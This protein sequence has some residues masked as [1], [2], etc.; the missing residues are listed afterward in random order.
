MASIPAED[1]APASKLSR[2]ISGVMACSPVAKA[3]MALR[4]GGAVASCAFAAQGI[5]LLATPDIQDFWEG[6][7]WLGQGLLGIIVGA[8]GTYHEVMGSM[9]SVTR[10]FK[11]FAMNRIGLCVFYL[12]MGCYIMGG[13]GVVHSGEA[14]TTV[15]HTTG[16]LAWAVAIGDLLVSCCYERHA[17]QSGLQSGDASGEETAEPATEKYVKDDL[18]ASLPPS[19]EIGAKDVE[20]DTDIAPASGW[21]RVGGKSFGGA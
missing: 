6:C 11:R 3:K 16:I 5:W 17:E 15:A 4:L 18:E 19:N 21:A 1:A 12:W 9:D 20:L 7:H 13:A 2:C 8:T 10:E 14:W